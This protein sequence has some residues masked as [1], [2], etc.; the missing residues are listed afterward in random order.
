MAD[1]FVWKAPKD[2]W[3]GVGIYHITFVVAERKRLLGELVALADSHAYSRSVQRFNDT[4]V[5]TS[6]HDKDP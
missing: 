3:K 5:N 4:D 6:R 2:I 1:E